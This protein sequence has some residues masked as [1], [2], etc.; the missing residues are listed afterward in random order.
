MAAYII[1]II[2]ALP[3]TITA[4]FTLLQIRNKIRLTK[5]EL[6][7]KNN[8]KNFLQTQASISKIFHIFIHMLD[9][10]FKNGGKKKLKKE[11]EKFIKDHKL[12]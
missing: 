9:E 12:K 10:E 2:V 3:T 8:N 1:S 11:V 7:D 6:N 4:F 5:L